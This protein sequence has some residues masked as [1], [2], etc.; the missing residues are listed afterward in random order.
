MLFACGGGDSGP[1]IAPVQGKVTLDGKPVPDALVVFKP[2]QGRPASAMTDTNGDYS[3]VYSQSSKGAALGK[4]RVEITTGR[5]ASFAEGVETSPAVKET[6]PEK[7]NSKTE[8]TAEI[9]AG[10]NVANFELQSK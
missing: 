3:L 9:T 8:L 7:Y 10:K 6:I 4:Y 1:T 5:E 2:E